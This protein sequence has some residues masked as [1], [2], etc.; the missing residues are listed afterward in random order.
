MRDACRHCS[1]TSP[2]LFLCSPPLRT[3][4]RTHL[5]LSCICSRVAD[6]AALASSGISDTADSIGKF[7]VLVLRRCYAQSSG[8]QRVPGVKLVGGQCDQG[9]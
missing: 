7:I 1:I 9:V 5:S 8:E 2:M 3:A 4:G 6:R